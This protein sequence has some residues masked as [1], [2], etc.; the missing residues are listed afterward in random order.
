MYKTRNTGMGNRIWGTREMGGM[1]HCQTFRR[2]SS[3]VSHSGECPQ[4]FRGM[5]PNIPGNAAKHSEECRQTISGNVLKHFGECLCYSRKG[6]P[7]VS[8]RFYP[9][10]FVFGV[11]QEN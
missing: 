8:P 10:V 4:T 5:L 6:G 11:N 3:N 1:L 2:M 9:F 7:R